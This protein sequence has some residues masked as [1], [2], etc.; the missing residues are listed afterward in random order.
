M[1]SFFYCSGIVP[2]Y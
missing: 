1:K 2:Q